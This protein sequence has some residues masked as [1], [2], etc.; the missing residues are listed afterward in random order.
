M[1]ADIFIGTEPRMW[2]GENVLRYSIDKYAGVN[3][4]NVH[5]MDWSLD[6]DT[7]HNWDMGRQPGIPA[8]RTKNEKGNDCW[9]TE[10]TNFRWAIPEKMNFT[11]RA[12][13]VDVDIIFLNDAHVLNELDMGGK[14][15]LSLTNTETSVMLFDCSQFNTFNWWPSIDE[16]KTNQWAM[17]NY[18]A[19]LTKHN[20]IGQLPLNWNCLD[21]NG[22]NPASTNLIHYTGMATQPWLPCQGAMKYYR[23]PNKRVEALW[24]ILYNEALEAGYVLQEPPAY[25]GLA[26]GVTDMFQQHITRLNYEYK[27]SGEIS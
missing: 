6:D 26:D 13:Y 5:S 3:A 22:F 24:A 2:R 9:F 12:I 8:T 18:L 1:M 11:G 17:R 15:L 27:I 19:L 7:W 10:F 20:V 16:M 21:G 25:G 4:H 14:A 23:H